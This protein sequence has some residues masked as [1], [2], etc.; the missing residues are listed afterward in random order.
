MELN[1]YL[2]LFSSHL[3]VKKMKGYR[4]FKIIVN[5]IGHSSV[6]RLSLFLKKKKAIAMPVFAHTEFQ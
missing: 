2:L 6:I 3:F 5:L 4:S 1:T